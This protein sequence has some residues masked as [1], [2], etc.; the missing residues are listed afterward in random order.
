TKPLKPLAEHIHWHGFNREGFKQHMAQCGGVI[1][2]AGFELASEAMTL[3]KKLLVKPLQGQF[4][5]SANVA[6]L[7]LLAAAESMQTL[8]PAV[9]KR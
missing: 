2:N 3:G 1:G 5:Q 8:D 7:E 9:L 6:A 4:E